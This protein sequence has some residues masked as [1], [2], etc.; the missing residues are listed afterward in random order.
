MAFSKEKFSTSLLRAGAGKSTIIDLYETVKASPDLNTT[1]KIY[2]FA[3]KKLKTVSGAVAAHYNMKRAIMELG[4]D[5]YPF[6]KFIAQLF[7]TQGFFTKTGE[8]MKGYC[9][10]HEVDVVAERNKQLLLME[11]KFHNH[12]GAKSDVKV[13]MYV[14]SRFEDIS[15]GLATQKK[16]VGYKIEMWVVTNTKFTTDAQKYGNCYDMHMLSWQ[17]PRSGSLAKLI[18]QAGIHPITALT[19]LTRTQKKELV[20]NGVVLCRQLVTNQK[21]MKKIGLNELAIKKI[22]HEAEEVMALKS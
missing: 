2:Q 12:P 18:N 11:C 10:T 17:N 7:N 13:A 19:C 9:V 4:P 5:G 1:G 3:L 8:I 16:Y 22:L 21:I 14:R 6:E 15:R 20:Y